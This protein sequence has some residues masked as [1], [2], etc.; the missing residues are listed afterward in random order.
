[1][2]GAGALHLGFKYPEL[3]GAVASFSAALIADTE[4]KSGMNLDMLNTMFGGHISRYDAEGAW[5]LVERNADK[6]RG[7]TNIRLICGDQD[8]L[9]ARTE[10]MAGILTRLKIPHDFIE[11]RGAP[12]SVKEVLARLDSDPFEF[13]GR[14]F[15][16]FK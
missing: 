16:S 15:A 2:G 7:R 6:I 8:Q 9:L 3:F 13:Y 11:S 10:W 14:A 5:T 12:H 1:M 4:I